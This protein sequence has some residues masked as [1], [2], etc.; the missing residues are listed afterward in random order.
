[1]NTII[2]SNNNKIQNKKQDTVKTGFQV[3]KNK[4]EK[5]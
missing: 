1:M 4:Y 5:L 2:Q 3:L